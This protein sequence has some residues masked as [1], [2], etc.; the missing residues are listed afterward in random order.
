MLLLPLG[1]EEVIGPDGIAYDINWSQD[2]QGRLVVLSCTA[3]PC[4]QQQQYVVLE[5]LQE[6]QDPMLQQQSGHEQQLEGQ[7]WTHHHHHHHQ[8]QQQRSQV[9]S[10]DMLSG[11]QHQQQQSPAS[12]DRGIHARHHHHQQQVWDQ[13]L[14]QQQQEQQESGHMGAV[15]P[16][17]HA[18]AVLPVAQE[19]AVSEA[20]LPRVSECIRKFTPGGPADSKPHAQ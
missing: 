5:G 12:L 17:Q 2:D 8:Q 9:A 19:G 1:E 18:T 20:H 13:Q 4:Q 7:Q 16:A 11:M 15:R 10:H 6:Q 3:K 14:L